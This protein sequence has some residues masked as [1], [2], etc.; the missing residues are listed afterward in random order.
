L[1]GLGQEQKG[2]AN[3]K[4]KGEQTIVAFLLKA[5]YADILSDVRTPWENKVSR[6]Q[7]RGMLLATVP[8]CSVAWYT[9]KVFDREM[10]VS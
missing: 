9:K 3:T 10:N 6:T 7:I 5:Y 4:K 1:F 8:L 2:C